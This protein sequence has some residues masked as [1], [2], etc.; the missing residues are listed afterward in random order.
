MPSFEIYSERLP[1]WL[2][3]RSEHLFRSRSRL[4]SGLQQRR[5]AGGD[6]VSSGRAAASGSVH[7]RIVFR[8]RH[9]ITVAYWRLQHSIALQ[10]CSSIAHI[11]ILLGYSIMLWIQG[12]LVVLLLSSRPIHLQAELIGW[13]WAWDNTVQG[14][15]D[16][17]YQ[18]ESR[19]EPVTQND[20]AGELSLSPF[21][22]I[23]SPFQ[24]WRVRRNFGYTV[25]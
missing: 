2:R 25:F 24:S 4:S 13:I 10:S 12:Q 14:E 21:R 1:L 5:Y 11:H 18:T 23:I 16:K 8:V 20:W 17:K 19:L 22:W 15:S 3:Y 6:T 7:R 9:S